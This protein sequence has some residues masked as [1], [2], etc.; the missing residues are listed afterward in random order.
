MA[1]A[2][3][4]TGRCKPQS[5]PAR[6]LRAAY[7]RRLRAIVELVPD[8]VAEAILSASEHISDQQGRGFDVSLGLR[9]CGVLTSG[10]SCNIL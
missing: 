3:I 7:K 8:W 5:V 2:T 1:G 4:D 6:L 9:R 10:G